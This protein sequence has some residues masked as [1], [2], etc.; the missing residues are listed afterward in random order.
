MIDQTLA[1]RTS[2]A[3]DHEATIPI[4]YKA[5]PTFPFNRLGGYSVFFWTNDQNSLIS[6]WLGCISLASTCVRASAWVAVT[7]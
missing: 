2:S 4:L 3:G 1:Q 7:R 6:I 5:S